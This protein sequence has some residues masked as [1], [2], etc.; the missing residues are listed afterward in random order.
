MTQTRFFRHYKNKPYKYLGLVRH[1]ETLEELV[2]YETL[3]ENENGKVWVRP[4]DMFFEK[5]IKN[6]Q[7]IH[8]FE[9]I[10]FRFAKLD[11]ISDETFKILNDLYAKT[12]GVLDL[13]KFKI[14]LKLN[15]KLLLL[16]AY[17][18]VK[19]VGFKLGY[20]LSESDFYSWYG[21]VIPDYRQ[22]GIASVLIE[23]QHEWCKKHGFII[24]K[25]KAKS[26]FAEM[27]SLN[28]KSGFEIVGCEKKPDTSLRIMFEKKLD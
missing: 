3:Y 25:T 18:G 10:E 9:P 19:P 7:L 2:L 6:G 24:I 22:L 4:K 14:K 1:S 13:K 23:K 17:D 8:R 20:A 11:T 16:L 21:G 28:L 27:I 5:I 15:L 12:L 26:T